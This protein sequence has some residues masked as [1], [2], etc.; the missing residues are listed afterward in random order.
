[1]CGIIGQLFRAKANYR[2]LPKGALES[3][4]HRGPD[5]NGLFVDE[6]IN[7]G[8]TRLS[9]IDLSD[10]ASQP[11]SSNDGRF[12]IVFNGEIYNYKTLR[13]QLEDR[14]YCFTSKSDTEVLLLAYQAYGSSCVKYI[15]GMFAFAVWDSLEEKLFLARDRFGEKPLYYFFDDEK[16]FFSS[17]LRSL[18]TLLEKKPGINFEAVHNFLC[19]QYVP[20]PST[21]I[22]G[23][24]RFPSASYVEISLSSWVLTPNKYWDYLT[25]G[26]NEHVTSQDPVTLI[27]EGI[28]S[29]VQKTLQADVPIAVALSGGIDSSAIAAIAAKY[30]SD[31]VHAFSV[32]YVGTPCYDERYQAKSLSNSLGLKFTQIEIS[33]K[34]FHDSFIELVKAMDEPVGDP[35]AYAH[36]A[37]PKSLSS[38]GYKVL[39]SGLGG[40]ELFWG[41]PWVRKSIFT[42]QL[43]RNYPLLR[44]LGKLFPTYSMQRFI[45][46]SGN[47][48]NLPDLVRSLI[49]LFQSPVGSEAKS[50]LVFYSGVPEYRDAHFLGKYFYGDAMGEVDTVVKEVI[51]CNP[52]FMQSH[53]LNKEIS[54]VLFE[55]WLK[56]N[57][58]TLS[59][60]LG[61]SVGVETRLPFLDASLIETLAAVR[62]SVEDHKMGH[63][64]LLKSAM[65]SLLP[66]EV[67]NR[68]KS[69][70]RVPIDE[71]IRPLIAKHADLMK[72]GTLTNLNIIR[73]EPIMKSLENLSS[74]K[75]PELFFLYKLL[76]LEIWLDK[77]EL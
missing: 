63:K 24:L 19:Y 17:E 52:N 48:Q 47:Y 2:P 28:E 64:W 58:L 34:D 56:C 23:V 37:V 6:K 66:D 12:F 44:C 31:Q 33:P 18:L 45:S 43:L 3:L 8:H 7:L 41:Y 26:L 54:S 16:L 77:I 67:L 32:G 74:I 50:K 75:W 25:A 27:R 69:G 22:E 14:G 49:G 40:D 9:I 53:D 29:A 57:C 11:M 60:R 76:V 36:L 10:D 68:P 61:M 30:S 65:R 62:V 5:A 51:E 39:L 70:F 42:N 73:V 71:W 38:H 72:N 59:D 15:E 4:V 35:S 13:L 55:L 1:M 20:E 46:R 21:L